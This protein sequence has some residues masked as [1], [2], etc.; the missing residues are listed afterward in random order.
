MQKKA[1]DFTT[2]FGIL[3]ALIIIFAAINISGSIR[4]FI[5]YPSLMIVVGGT[6]SVTSAC[7]SF[8]EILSSHGIIFNSILYQLENP[9]EAAMR[10]LKLAEKSRNKTLIELEKQDLTKYDNFL[11]KGINL[12]VEGQSTENIE[13]I[14]NQELNSALERNDKVTSILRKS[15]EIAPAMGLI[16]TLIGLV[17]MLGSLDDPSKIGPF[18]AIGLLTT[19]YGAALG[20]VVFFPLASKVE[21]NSREENIIANVYLQTVLSIARKENPRN[22]ENIINS[23]L[24]PNNKIQ[25]FNKN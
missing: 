4:A 25:Y 10:A 16:G 1:L 19:F 24:S 18:M 6:F 3:I 21:H 12:V 22:L 13:K 9:E 8:R 17:Q 14:L 15:A 7:F 23:L 11:R 5:D 20:Y 2:I